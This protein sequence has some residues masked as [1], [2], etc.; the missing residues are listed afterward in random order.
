[1]G[2]PRN[3]DLCDK[4]L[5]SE[6]SING[7]GYEIRTVIKEA[8]GHTKAQEACKVCY[9]KHYKE[10]YPKEEAPAL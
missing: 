10:K 1:M 5:V 2:K 9:L 7:V 3:C 4:P 8:P 6:N